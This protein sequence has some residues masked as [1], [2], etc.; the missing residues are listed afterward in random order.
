MT[1]KV[2][3]VKLHNPTYKSIPYAEDIRAML[4]SINIQ[5]QNNEEPTVAWVRQMH[6]ENNIPYIPGY[7][8][9]RILQEIESNPDLQ[10]FV[11]FIGLDYR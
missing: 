8:D 9:I 7:I 5:I 10:A 1:I 4:E 2:R 11:D 3:F 6:N